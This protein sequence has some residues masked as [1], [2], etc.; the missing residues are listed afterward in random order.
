LD[1]GNCDLEVRAMNDMI[2]HDMDQRYDSISTAA[3]KLRADI[4][5]L[6]FIKG[7]LPRTRLAMAAS[8]GRIPDAREYIEKAT[9]IYV[10]TLVGYDELLT[11]METE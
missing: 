7:R 8:N 4:K 1:S 11:S 10:A 3:E 9:E 5:G 6:D 2:A